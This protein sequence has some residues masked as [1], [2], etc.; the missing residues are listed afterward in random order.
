MAWTGL[1]WIA[2]LLRLRL[3]I[4][5]AGFGPLD[6]PISRLISWAALWCPDAITVRDVPSLLTVRRIAKTDK[7]WSGFD[8]VGLSK[9]LITANI[10]TEPGDRRIIGVSLCSLSEFLQNPESETTY[11]NNL[12]DAISLVAQEERLVVRLYGL[13]TTRS[14]GGDLD[15]V[16]QVKRRLPTNL[17]VEVCLYPSNINALAHSISQCDAF[18]AARY[19]A[20][21]VSFLSA[22]PQAVV[23]YNRKVRDLAEQIQLPR[24]LIIDIEKPLSAERWGLILRRLLSCGV[25]AK[26]SA[27][28]ASQSAETSIAAAIRSIGLNFKE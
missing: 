11:W 28:Q 16:E 1:F 7:I 6:H 24:D 20:A 8:T 4:I 21:L 13:Y 3:L 25:E 9:E 19:H 12:T 10:P 14:G 17:P 26:L 23:C 27:E 15:F 2:R 5:G 22:R 18:V